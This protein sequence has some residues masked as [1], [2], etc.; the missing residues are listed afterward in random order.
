MNKL[1]LERNSNIKK[2]KTCKDFA[3]RN[4]AELA[5][6]YTKID[7]LGAGLLTSF[8]LKRQMSSQYTAIMNSLEKELSKL[9]NQKSSQLIF[10]LGT[11]S[12]ELPG[13]ELKDSKNQK[14]TELDYC[15]C[16][17][18][19]YQ[20]D[21]DALVGIS[22]NWE[23]CEPRKIFENEVDISRFCFPFLESISVKES[24]AQSLQLKIEKYVLGLMEQNNFQFWCALQAFVLKD[25][26]FKTPAN[27]KCFS[28]DKPK[29]IEQE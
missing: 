26:K 1:I 12:R 23:K 8:R 15:E 19:Y 27:F 14:L 17:D 16:A 11:F 13:F 21:R 29:S 10:F 5:S 7:N 9:T 3:F 18:Y 25:L 2:I 28:P 24:T 20:F 22:R 6:Y 4:S